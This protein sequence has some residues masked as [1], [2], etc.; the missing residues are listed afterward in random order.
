VL[1]ES[2]CGGGWAESPKPVFTCRLAKL[3]VWLGLRAGFWEARL[4]L[5]C[6][7]GIGWCMCGLRVRGHWGRAGPV[8]LFLWQNN[9]P[10]SFLYVLGSLQ[11]ELP[12]RREGACLAAMK[13]LYIAKSFGRLFVYE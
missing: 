6:A 4:L 9:Y 11:G 1:A 7:L 13:N 2:F 3:G 5:R 12:D 8:R 10:V